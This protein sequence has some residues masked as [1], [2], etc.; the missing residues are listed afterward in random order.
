M[1]DSLVKHQQDH[2]NKIA[3]KYHEARNNPRS[4][5]LKKNIWEVA[6]RNKHLWNLTEPV[7]VL[8]AMC[9]SADGYKILQNNLGLEFEYHG[10]DYSEEMIHYAQ[11]TYPFLSFSIQDATTYISEEMYDLI[12][13]I[14][15][16]H[17]VYSAVDK[18]IYNLSRVL[19]NG[20]IFIN[21]E[22]TNN[23]Y[24]F[25]KIRSLIYKNNALFDDLTEKA[26][27]TSELHRVFLNHGLKISDTLH[28]GL[29]AYI[30]WYNPDAFPFLNHGSLKF[31]SWL[32]ALEDK[33]LWR[34]RLAY[35][36][37]FATLTVYRKV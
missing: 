31:V 14:G 6:F 15:G 17:H 37:S 26:F 20:G 27:E 12:I 4:E 24:L 22:P 35:Y 16:L 34:T 13:L 18:V 28:P 2:F 9:G 11:Q 1:T 3:H 7:K 5:L 32:S 21:F 36:M 30:L 29:L 23:N 33:F 8:E 19:K 10:F 25:K